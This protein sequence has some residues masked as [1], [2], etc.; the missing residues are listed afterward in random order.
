[1]TDI[2]NIIYFDL[3]TLHTY[4][5]LKLFNKEDKDPMKLRMAIGGILYEEDGTEV[6]KFFRENQVQQLIETLNK[7]DLII[8]HNILRF[9]Y[10]V[11]QQY[12]KENIN[13]LLYDKTFDTFIKLLPF[14][15][16]LWTSLDNLAQL[17]LGICKPHSGEKIPGMWRNNQIK[18]VEEYLLNDLR[19][20]RDIYNYIKKNGKVKYTYKDYGRVVGNVEVKVDW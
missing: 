16:N 13:N 8:G 10:K 12:H 4:Q 2:K 3:E 19:M 7:A 1:M 11:L 5:E 9:D 18:E 14:T 20:T 15:D 17:N 6:H